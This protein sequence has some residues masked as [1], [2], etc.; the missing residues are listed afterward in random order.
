MSDEPPSDQTPSPKPLRGAQVPP[1]EDDSE[2]PERWEK[3]KPRV[4]FF[5]GLIRVMVLGIILVALVLPFTPYA[6]RVKRGLEKIV[7]KARET[8]VIFREVPKTVIEERKVIEE[9]TVVKEKLV[10][11]PAPPPPLP[12]KFIPRKEVDVATLYN[13]IT[14]QTKLDAQ[15]GNF[16]SVERLDKDAFTVEFQLK[17]R[18]PKPNSTL[19]ELSRINEN[20]PK[21]LPGLEP[22]LKDA[23]VSGFYHKLYERKTSMVQ[24]NL[25]R[26]NKILDRHNFFDCETILELTHPESKRRVLL[27]QSE[28]DVVADG[29][30]G[31][32][33]PEMSSSIYNSDYYQPFT[34]YEWAKKTQ[35]PNPLL[36]RWQSRQE[37]VKKEYASK[38]LSAARNAEL[39][40][41]LQ[42]IEATIRALKSRSSLI[43][44]KDPFIVISLLFKDYPKTHPHAP[45][46][47]DYA[48]VLHG[49]K[50]YP[51]ICG[52]YGPTMKMGE[53]SLL[54]A[55]TINEKSTPYIRPESDLKVTYLI[56]PGTADKPFGPPDVN[57]WQEKVN[58]YLRECGGLGTGYE[59]HKWEQFP[60]PPPVPAPPATTTPATT[61][62]PALA[63]GT[64]PK[65]GETQPAAPVVTGSAP[66]IPPTGTAPQGSVPPTPPPTT[67][68]SPALPTT[69]PG[70]PPGV[71]PATKTP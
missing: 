60:P 36:A 69:P 20:L 17:V 52:D 8:K 26:L 71:I 32:R 61:T 21:V 43:A 6:G 70:T 41:E 25:T 22:M 35:T 18:V 58:A 38:G 4:G 30:D 31:D 42:Q 13:G 23:K 57:K 67:P 14:I 11:V 47:G 63:T 48:A 7:D 55:K 5:G 15:E 62:E 16:A 27:I 9:K 39:K 50:I 33:M 34:S 24:Q 1:P 59:L 66:V 12:S 54:M 44:E 56:F 10:E 46:I 65:P 49:N 40:G 53:A 37:S 51:A 28:M 64:A 45:S 29:S 3:R 68:G 2:L 19:P